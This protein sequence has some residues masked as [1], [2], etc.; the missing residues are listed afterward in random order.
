MSIALR[1]T[2]TIPMEG[3]LEAR[4]EEH[5]ETDTHAEGTMS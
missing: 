3:T 5:R 2:A 4:V 1:R